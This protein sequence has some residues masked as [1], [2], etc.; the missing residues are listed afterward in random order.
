[1]IGTQI[2]HGVGAA[3]AAKLRGKDE[4][5]SIH[6]GDGATS[7]NGFHSGLNWAAVWN[8]PCVFVCVDNGWAI[9]VCSKDQ[10]AAESYADKAIAYGMPGEQ[11][12]GNDV[13]ACHAAMKRAHD[14]A[15]KGQGPSL[16]VLETYRMMGH[17][18]SDDPSKYREQA[19]VTRGPEGSD[20]AV[21]KV[22]L[23]ALRCSGSTRRRGT[24]YAEST[25]RSACGSRAAG[26]A[27]GA[28]RG[29][30]AGAAT[31]ARGIQPLHRDRG[32][33]GHASQA[34]ARFRCSADRGRKLRNGD[35]FGDGY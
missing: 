25:P 8:L 4:V 31:S 26:G 22:L 5:H 23:E 2:P 32:H 19:E 1:V 15:L 28:C 16:I 27:Q 10:T 21:K 6:F 12:D 18:S 13:L 34:T 11:V 24:G 29:R 7:S 33:Q 20:C 3:H 17:S 30:H 9:S 14:R 35:V